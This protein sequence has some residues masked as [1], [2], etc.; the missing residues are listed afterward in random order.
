MKEFF[1][2]ADDEHLTIQEVRRVR[3]IN[4]IINPFGLPYLSVNPIKYNA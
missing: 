4:F 2:I 3:K 1:K